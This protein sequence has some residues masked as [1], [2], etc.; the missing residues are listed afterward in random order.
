MSGAVANESPPVEG[1][2]PSAC[3]GC[4]DV[5]GCRSAW[6]APH[7]GPFSP[8]GLSLGSAVAFL[9][10]IISAI[11]VGALVHSHKDDSGSILWDIA[12]A[13]VGLLIGAALALLV[14]PLIKKHLP[15]RP[16]N[17]TCP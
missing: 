12:G 2:E 4:P 14:M 13:V 17:R 6:S 1:K 5:D 8:A 15:N 7:Q 9:L 16:T 3:G 10:P 11:M